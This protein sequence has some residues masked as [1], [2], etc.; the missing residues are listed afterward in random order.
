MSEFLQIEDVGSAEVT[1]LPDAQET[2]NLLLNQARTVTTVD[3]EFTAECAADVL[4]NLSAAV[5]DMEAARKVVKAPVLDLGKRID[6]VA[7]NW[8]TGLQAEEKR[9]K[10]VLGDYQA[11]ERRK[12]EEAERAAREAEAEAKRKAEEALAAGDVE[13]ASKAADEVAASK[14]QVAA[15]SHKIE[16][17]SVR[18]TWKFEVV[19]V[20]ALFKAA[21]HLCKIEP[22]NGL[23]RETIKVDQSIPGLR[24]WKEATSY[25][26]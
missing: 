25:A 5:R 14:A 20:E 21:P 12:R 11:A 17:V 8:A 24:I 19:D 10:R 16:G 26:R 7:K 6:S 3:D 9:I 22:N 23:I 2:R 18:E 1:L 4:K 15:S 13:A